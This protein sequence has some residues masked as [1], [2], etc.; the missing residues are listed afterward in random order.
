M[1]STRRETLPNAQS[2]QQ[3]TSDL[4][5]FQPAPAA[6]RIDDKA[7]VLEAEIVGLKQAF[8]RER[9]IYAYLGLLLFLAAI[10]PHVPLLVFFV[11]VFGS[12]PLL[13]AL[14]TYWDFPWIVKH[15]EKWQ[16][17]AVRSA[18]RQISGEGGA[19]EPRDDKK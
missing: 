10:G 5:H 13:L 17:V 2:E 6:K 14:G 1:K 3:N 12:I 9:Y 8:S 15:L 18:D 4:D 7:A 19:T 16:S 11:L